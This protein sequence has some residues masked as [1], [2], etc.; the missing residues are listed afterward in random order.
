MD[1]EK[2][3]RKELLKAYKEYDSIIN[4]TECF[5]VNDLRIFDKICSEID[6]RGIEVRG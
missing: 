6:K 1:V 4:V 3:S 2:M 5:G